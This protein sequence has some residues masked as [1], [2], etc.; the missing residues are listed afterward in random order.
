MTQPVDVGEEVGG[1]LESVEAEDQVEGVAGVVA[2]YVVVIAV[3]EGC[4]ALVQTG[5]QPAEETHGGQGNVVNFPRCQHR[6]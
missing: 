6:L 4:A 5:A 3:V 1:E 2:I